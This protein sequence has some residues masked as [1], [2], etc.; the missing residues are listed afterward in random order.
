MSEMETADVEQETTSPPVPATRTP[1]WLND[2]VRFY[3]AVAIGVALAFVVP[4]FVSVRE[5]ANS[6]VASTPLPLGILYGGVAVSAIYFYV[7]H[8][9]SSDDPVIPSLERFSILLLLALFALT[10]HH[11]GASARVDAD[12]VVIFE[13]LLALLQESTHPFANITSLSLQT[14]SKG[15]TELAINR[16]GKRPETYRCDELVQAILPKLSAA[17]QAH[18]IPVNG[19]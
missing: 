2:E 18:N 14:N 8:R 13:P 12:K 19:F 17:A 9:R 4:K 10:T 5:D 3:A 15:K 11:V 6:V 7:R 1:L 16:Q